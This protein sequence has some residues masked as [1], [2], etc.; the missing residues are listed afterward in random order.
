M[1]EEKLFSSSNK[2]HDTHLIR[3]NHWNNWRVLP[4][5]DKFEQAVVI[6]LSGLIAIIVV[7]AVWNLS[8]KVISALVWGGAFD[9]ADHSVFQ[10]IFGMIITVIIALEF[11]RSILV[12]AERRFGIVQVRAV[13]LIGMLVIV[14]KFIILDLTNVE[15][16]L[17]FG[18]STAVLA[19]GVVYWTVR[20]QDIKERAEFES[21]DAQ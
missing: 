5:Y 8:I 20:D 14:R 11:K 6:I 16:L 10:A 18:L 2:E 7:S 3:Q 4:I 17:L 21:S 13:I 12:I 9:P 1:S 15:P 19:L